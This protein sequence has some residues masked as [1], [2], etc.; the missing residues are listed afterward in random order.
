CAPITRG[1]RAPLAHATL[2]L[3]SGGVVVD[4]SRTYRVRVLLAMRGEVQ[5]AV[6]G[7]VLL[8]PVPARHQEQQ[9]ILGDAEHTLLA[10]HRPRIAT[11]VSPGSCRPHTD[12]RSGPRAADGGLPCRRR[13]PAGK[14]A[15]AKKNQSSGPRPSS[16]LAGGPWARGRDRG[17]P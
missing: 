3:L 1:C 2:F 15:C 9:L 8:A 6:H 17:R 11:S 13:R 5:H 14:M 12:S 10:H 16:M 7:R 4:A